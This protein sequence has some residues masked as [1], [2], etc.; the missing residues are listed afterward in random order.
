[1]GTAGK[2]IKATQTD[3]FGQ[4]LSK[5]KNDWRINISIMGLNKSTNLPNTVK[6]EK[7]NCSLSLVSNG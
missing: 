7:K 6:E 4:V 2:S 3:Y 1:M 5:D